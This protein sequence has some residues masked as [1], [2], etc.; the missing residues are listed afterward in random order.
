VSTNDLISILEQENYTSQEIVEML[1]NVDKNTLENYAVDN[2]ICIKC[3][4]DLVTKSIKEDRGEHFGFPSFETMAVLEC[5]K[6][7]W[8]DC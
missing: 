2:M 1:D 5:K 4:S 7:G 8:V 3:Y 6:C